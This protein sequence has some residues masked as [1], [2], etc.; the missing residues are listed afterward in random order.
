MSDLRDVLEWHVGAD[1]V[2]GVVG[3]AA[4]GDRLKVQAASFADAVG[5]SPMARDSILRSA[6]VIGELPL[7]VKEGRG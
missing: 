7:P 4:R 5:S 2:P 3:V 1:T 6:G